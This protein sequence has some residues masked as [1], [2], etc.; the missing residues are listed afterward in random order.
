MCELHAEVKHDVCWCCAE[1]ARCVRP[2]TTTSP[3][4]TAF[5]QG[6]NGQYFVPGEQLMSENEAF[7]CL[8]EHCCWRTECCCDVPV[9]VIPHLSDLCVLCNVIFTFWLMLKK[10]AVWWISSIKD[11]EKVDTLVIL[12]CLLIQKVKELFVSASAIFLVY[13]YCIKPLLHTC[14]LA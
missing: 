10:R 4:V 8:D 14:T 12:N 3:S 9:F 2:N 1:E 13:W 6:P 7:S 5:V 11:F